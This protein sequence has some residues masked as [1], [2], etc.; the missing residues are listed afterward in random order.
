VSYLRYSENGVNFY[1][2]G[3]LVGERKLKSDRDLVKEMAAATAEAW[4]AAEADPAGAVTSMTGASEQLPPTPVVTEQFKT[5][6][7]LLHT[8]ATQGKA[9]GVN[10]EDDWK[11]TIAL[12]QQTGVIGKA[13]APSKYWSPQPTAQG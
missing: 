11:Q 12:F 6:L 2:N 9:P 10:T 8:Q 5:T 1:S 7:T 4:T 3:L 13:E